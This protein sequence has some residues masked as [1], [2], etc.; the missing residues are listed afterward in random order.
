MKNDTITDLAEVRAAREWS[1]GYVAHLPGDV[2]RDLALVASNGSVAD[3]GLLRQV[4]ADLAEGI[5]RRRARQE[6]EA[7]AP[8]GDRD[9]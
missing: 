6:R 3:L 7:F 5:V 8:H 9:P 4:A 1:L 2:L